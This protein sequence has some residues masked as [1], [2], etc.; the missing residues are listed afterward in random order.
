MIPT[1]GGMIRMFSYVIDNQVKLR[2]LK[3]K[4]A[5]NMFNVVDQSRGYLREWL[6]WVDTTRKAEDCLTFIDQTI[7]NAE[8]QQALTLGIF[9]EKKFAG[10]VGFNYFDW[11]NKIAPIGYWLAPQFQGNG[12]M[13]TSVRS[14]IDIGFHEIGL[15]RI[16]IRAAVQNQKSRSIPERLDF[17]EEGLIR[18]GEWLY[19]HYVDLIIYGKLA[20]EWYRFR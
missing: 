8:N 17:K 3:L 13:T 6:P 12:I 9:V 4:D 11:H 20:S 19:D 7:R 1:L 5:K 10:L 18:Q 14:L 2:Q 16:E 15:N